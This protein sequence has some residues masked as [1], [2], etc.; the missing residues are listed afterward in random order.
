MGGLWGG[1][2]A[3]STV[4]KSLGPESPGS[5]ALAFIVCIQTAFK[6]QVKGLLTWM[7]KDKQN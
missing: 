5:D 2:G 7:Q 1:G 4:F 3:K 6:L